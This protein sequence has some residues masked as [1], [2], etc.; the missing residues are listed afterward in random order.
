MESSTSE[1]DRARQRLKAQILALRG[2][3]ERPF[4]RSMKQLV[5]GHENDRKNNFERYITRAS[6]EYSPEVFGQLKA[7][8]QDQ[9]PC[10]VSRFLYS[11]GGSVSVDFTH[12]PPPVAWEP[13]VVDMRRIFYGATIPPTDV[14]NDMAAPAGFRPLEHGSAA[15][16]SPPPT[17][18]GSSP[19]RE[20]AAVEKRSSARGRKGPPSS[21]TPQQSPRNAKRRFTR[22]G[23]QHAG[24]VIK[25]T[26]ATKRLE[27][28]ENLGCAFR[29]DLGQGPRYYILRCP[30]SGCLFT[31]SENPFKNNLAAA[32]FAEC[33]VHYSDEAD[34]VR[35]YAYQVQ[36]QRVHQE[37]Q[38]VRKAWV[39]IYNQRVKAKRKLLL[40]ERRSASKS[41]CAANGPTPESS[42]TPT[43]SEE[44]VEG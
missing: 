5:E 25:T 1:L 7:W 12:T 21:P 17:D 27:R 14:Q 39:R 35:R 29:Y 16:N 40:Q 15:S 11:Q 4:Q 9:F 22:S 34:I 23:S 20:E 44:S 26:A 18:R 3:T 33:N 24:G 8:I 42:E 36:N 2:E 32:H 6:L 30:T 41:P 37:S 38:E 28:G 43:A 19:H 10:Y 31:F 13:M